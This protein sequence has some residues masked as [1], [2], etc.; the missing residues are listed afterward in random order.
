[1]L[2]SKKPEVLA[3]GRYLEGFSNPECKRFP[4]FTF[5]TTKGMTPAGGNKEKKPASDKDMLD[6]DK[7]DGSDLGPGQYKLPVDLVDPNN[8]QGETNL[9]VKAHLPYPTVSFTLFCI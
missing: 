8:L 2:A 1:M 4:A 6:Q 7:T 5:P 9:R 3:F